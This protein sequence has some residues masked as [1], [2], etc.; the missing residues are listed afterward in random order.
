MFGKNDWR[1]IV[2]FHIAQ[3]WISECLNFSEYSTIFIV[4]F[5]LL[6]VI[7]ADNIDSNIFVRIW[8]RVL[9]GSLLCVC[10]INFSSLFLDDRSQN[11]YLANQKLIFF[12]YL[13]SYIYSISI[14]IIQLCHR[15]QVYYIKTSLK[16]SMPRFEILTLNLVKLKFEEFYWQYLLFQWQRHR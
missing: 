11:K 8:M 9:E 3:Y 6:L 15:D 1:P 13:F 2:W 14:E 7:G 10:F 4:L 12:W 16:K 5:V